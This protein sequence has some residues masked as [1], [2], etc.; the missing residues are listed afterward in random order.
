VNPS[1]SNPNLV[2]P[3]GTQVVSRITLP[4]CPQGAVGVT[5]RSPTDNSHAYCIQLPNGQEVTLKQHEL[6][7]R[8][9]YQQAGLQPSD[10]LPADNSSPVEKP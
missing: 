4:E 5:V 7:I 6:T 1:Y 3:V 8:K 10:H 2:L 9:H